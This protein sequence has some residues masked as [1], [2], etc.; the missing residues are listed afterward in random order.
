MIFAGFDFQDPPTATGVGAGVTGVVQDELGKTGE[1]P[2]LVDGAGVFDD[3]GDVP[4]GV[5]KPAAQRKSRGPL[6]VLGASVLLC[7][8]VLAMVFSGQ[9]DVGA[10]RVISSPVTDVEVWL[11][12]ES[13]GQGSPLIHEG[14]K[15]GV[16]YKLR[17]KAKGYADKAYLFEAPAGGPFDI[18]IEL[19]PLPDQAPVL[20]GTLQVVSEPA[21]AKVRLNNEERGED[22]VDH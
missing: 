5:L 22:S 3:S 15:A 17:V 9:S 6:V 8:S 16:M 14:L 11:D 2:A 18:A 1:V 4:T 7:A 12:G 20:T 21:G 19:D 10:I 13:I